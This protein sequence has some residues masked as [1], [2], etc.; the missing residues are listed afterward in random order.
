M[1]P[2]V[3]KL[4]L[5]VAVVVL[6]AIIS[7]CIVCPWCWDCERYPP[8][9]AQIYVHALDYYTGMPINWA[10]V[11]LYEADWWSWDYIGTWTVNGAGHTPVYGGYLYRDGNGGPEDS[12][13]RVTVYASGYQSESYTL[14]LDYYH[15][16]ESLYFYIVPFPAREGG[17]EPGDEE[18]ESG[19]VFEGEPREDEPRQAG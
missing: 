4:M 2:T 11:D 9:M 15:P 12:V 19:K 10:S 16:T 17:G 13:F 7:G 8:R 14:E 1:R 18:L 3:R 6:P 5:L